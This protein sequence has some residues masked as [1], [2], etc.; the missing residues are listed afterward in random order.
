LFENLR[1]CFESNPF[2]IEDNERVILLAQEAEPNQQ[3]QMVEVVDE[4]GPIL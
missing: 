4:Q 3:F 2:L 1:K